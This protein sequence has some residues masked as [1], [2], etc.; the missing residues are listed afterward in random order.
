MKIRCIIVEDERMA[1]EG[2]QSYIEQYDFLQLVQSFSNASDALG[3]L[4]EKT[5]QLLFLD[6]EMPGMKGIEMAK[7]LNGMFPMIVFTTAYPQYALEAHD[8]NA[9][10]YLVK[11]IFPEDFRRVVR[12]IR[13][14][15]GYMEKDS[16]GSS[17]QIIIK[18]E[19]EWLRIVPDDILYMKSM[20]NYVVIYLDS[21]KPQMVLQ[22]LKDIRSL[23]PF[24]FIQTHRSYIVNLKRVEKV[25]DLNIYIGHISI[26]MSRTRKKEVTEAFLKIGQLM[27]RS[28]IEPSDGPDTRRADAY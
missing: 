24:Y 9:I 28:P 25:S 18:C 26:P 15:F 23:L 27:H 10:G 8:V 5:I 20:Q 4:K 19:R 3:F 11:P 17:E 13:S 2:L 16:T 22:P 12:K 14:F 7:Q 6:I 21:N 1:R